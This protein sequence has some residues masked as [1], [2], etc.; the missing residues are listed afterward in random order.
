VP[1]PEWVIVGRVRKAHGLEGELVVEP[2][3]DRPGAIFAPGRRVVAGTPDGE[4][5]RDRRELVVR[6]SRP[7]KGGLLVHFEGIASREESELWRA[8]FLLVPGAELAPLEEGEV[9]VHDLYGMRVELASGEA[10]GVVEAVYELPQGHR[11]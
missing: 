9:Y 4:V 7:F 3:T 8:R 1:T 11:A 5:A 10:L 2:I 6:S